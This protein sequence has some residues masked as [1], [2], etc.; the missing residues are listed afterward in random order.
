M[1]RDLFDERDKQFEN[2][3][4]KILSTMVHVLDGVITFLD[5]SN[6]AQNSNLIW[7]DVILYHDSV[8]ENDFVVLV[9]SVT[10]NI[11]DKLSLPNGEVIEVTEDNVDYFKRTIR[12][13]VPYQLASEGTSDEVVE[14]LERAEQEAEKK[15]EN[16]ERFLQEH[17]SA[18]SS[19]STEFDLDDLTEKQRHSYQLFLRTKGGKS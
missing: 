18:L 1:L 10:Y 16:L 19:S 11:G 12:V 9:G 8:I 15:E 3:T 4:I 6:E 5:L 17:S 2:F 7:E 14:Y 13:G